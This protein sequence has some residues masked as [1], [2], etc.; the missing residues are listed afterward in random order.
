MK[1][2]EIA[3]IKQINGGSNP[4]NTIIKSKPYQA[5]KDLININTVKLQVTKWIK[6]IGDKEN[7]IRNLV[8][9]S[10]GRNNRTLPLYNHNLPLYNSN[11]PQSAVICHS[12]P[13]L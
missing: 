7:G 10:A 4:I 6:R 3:E 2:K 5:L 12:L 13:V 1:K 8:N 9:Y 11:L